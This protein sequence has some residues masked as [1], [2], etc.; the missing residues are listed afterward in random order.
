MSYKEIADIMETTVSA[1]ESLIHRAKTNL[2]KKL[3]KYYE[4]NLI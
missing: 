3:Y 2:K 4:R 1:V